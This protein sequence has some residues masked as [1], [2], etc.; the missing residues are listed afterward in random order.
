MPAPRWRSTAS[1]APTA[2][3]AEI[4]RPACRCSNDGRFV[5]SSASRRSRC[6]PTACAGPH[7]G[8]SPGS[9][10]SGG[11]GSRSDRRTW[12]STRRTSPSRDR[13]D[14]TLKGWFV[15]CPGDDRARPAVLV[16]HGW[17][18]AASLM[19]PIASL[20]HGAGLHALFLDARGHGRSD[21]D[22]F[23]SMPRFAEDI[24][25]GLRWLRDD[26]R[27]EPDCV[28]L[29]GHSVGAGASL[30][31]ASRDPRIAAVVSIATMAHPGALMP[32]NLRARGCRARSSPRS[33]GR[34]NAPSAG[35]STR[36]L[37]SRRS[38]ASVLPSSL[39]MVARRG[40]STGRR[41]AP[42]AGVRGRA[43]T[44]DRPG[45]RPRLTRCVSPRRSRG[46]LVHPGRGAHG[47]EDV[48]PR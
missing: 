15:E 22:R 10:R 26:A 11:R 23:S 38:P 42:G 6:S 24:D 16:I 47:Q 3:R 39:S 12:P 35:R 34:S 7:P 46:D 5:S 27:V 36:S 40:R 20:V 44:P 32:A 43:R 8:R 1:C 25:A 19:L 17:N 13:I 33:C 18:G 30:L 4:A 31:A 37:R 48:A 9:S 14:R 29:L 28:V 41:D 2:P 45:R 21:D